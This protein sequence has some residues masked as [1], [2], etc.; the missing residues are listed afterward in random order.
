[1]EDT[2]ALP[3]FPD[4]E[5]FGSSLK[6]DSL[7]PGV[8]F[9]KTGLT[10]DQQR[11]LVQYAMFASGVLG[12]DGKYNLEKETKFWTVVDGQRKFNSA[13]TRGRIYE[14]LHKLPE[15]QTLLEVG[16]HSITSLTPLDL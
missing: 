4:L 14:A 7:E 10:P 2:Q 15:T 12:E 5:A 9:V 6:V 3:P 11:W 16:L 1:M 8:A 13:Y